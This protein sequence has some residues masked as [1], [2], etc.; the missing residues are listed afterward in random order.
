[1]AAHLD[2]QGIEAATAAVGEYVDRKGP[3]VLAREATL[4]RTAV[5]AYLAALPPAR[6][7]DEMVAAVDAADVAGPNL[8]R[9]VLEAALGEET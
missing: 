9:R 1:M 5:T 2:E 6:T 3:K 7:L 4:A 8:A